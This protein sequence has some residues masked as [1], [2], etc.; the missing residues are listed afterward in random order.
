MTLVDKIKLVS[1]VEFNNTSYVYDIVCSPHKIKVLNYFRTMLI[2]WI[3][4]PLSEILYRSYFAVSFWLLCVFYKLCLFACCR[5]VCM[6]W[7]ERDREKDMRL[8]HFLQSFHTGT[9]WSLKFMRFHSE[10]NLYLILVKN[11]QDTNS[12]GQFLTK[13]S[14]QSFLEHIKCFFLVL[15]ALTIYSTGGTFLTWLFS[16]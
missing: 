2:M 3:T 5:C 8:I 1:S 7:G 11:H 14:A 13:L 10:K 16:Y 9:L 6:V 12:L 4:I 15:T